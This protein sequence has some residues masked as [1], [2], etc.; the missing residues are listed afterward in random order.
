MSCDSGSVFECVWQTVLCGIAQET[1]ERPPY[2][3]S[4]NKST[5]SWRR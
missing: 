2:I 4:R 1:N 3:V 5:S